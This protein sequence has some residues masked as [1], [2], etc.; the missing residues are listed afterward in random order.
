M[1]SLNWTIVHPI[2]ENSPLFDMKPEDFETTESG[3]AILLRAFDDTF[4]QTVHS[5][6]AYQYTDIVWNAKF[7]PVFH[8]DDNGRIVL[9]LSKISDYELIKF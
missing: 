4:S 5:R 2:D 7:K 9:D 6:T 8:R 3:F 1:L